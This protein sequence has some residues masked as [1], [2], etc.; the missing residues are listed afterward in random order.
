MKKKKMHPVLVVL[1][2]VLFAS[3]A[4]SDSLCEAY[5]CATIEENHVEGDTNQSYD[6]EPIESKGLEEK[7]K[8]FHWDDNFKGPNGGKLL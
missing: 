6:L 8:G 3:C 1:L 4:S 5:V 2:M 7:P